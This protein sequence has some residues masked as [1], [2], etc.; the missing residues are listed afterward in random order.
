MDVMQQLVNGAPFLE[1]REKINDNFSEIARAI[2]EDIVPISD[3]GF[4]V[5]DSLLGE[6]KSFN[7]NTSTYD[8]A[9]AV[10]A[11]LL[12]VLKIKGVI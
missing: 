8:E 11:T 10:I 7:P 12:K 4:S 1:Q 9:M 3:E 2:E 5:T 6:V